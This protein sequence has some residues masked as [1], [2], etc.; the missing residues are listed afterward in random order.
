MI[1]DKIMKKIMY[2]S[3]R[4]FQL[5]S[6]VLLSLGANLLTNSFDEEFKG[7]NQFQIIGAFLFLISSIFG[8]L[9]SGIRENFQSETQSQYQNQFI[10]KLVNK[11]NIEILTYE[12]IL[13]KNSILGNS[14]TKWERYLL[15]FIGFGIFGI[16]LLVWG[17][18]DCLFPNLF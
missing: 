6:T 3:P 18:K 10:N 15:I 16:L 11:S 14:R 4:N 13:I 2:L 9:E 1:S 12:E 8:Y 17:V 7:T 5:I